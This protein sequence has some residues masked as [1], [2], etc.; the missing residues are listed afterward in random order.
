MIVILG[1]PALLETQGAGPDALGGTAACAALAARNSGASVELVGSV[2]DDAVGDRI[3]IALGQAG[4]GHAAVLRDPSPQR[5]PRLDA[6]DASLGLS[7]VTECRVLLV[8]EPLPGDVLAVAAEAAAYHGAHLIAVV[9]DTGAIASVALPADATLLQAPT[10]EGSEP[11]DP[12][13]FG[14]TLGRYAAAL[15]RGVP[16]DKAFRA[17]LAGGWEAVT[18]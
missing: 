7:Y 14:A 13:D 12:D 3:V 1:R 17:A 8:A 2:P 18:E 11:G 10:A 4:I 5:P 16:A 15:A 9:A 6:A